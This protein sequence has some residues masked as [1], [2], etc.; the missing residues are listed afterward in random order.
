[1]EP[2]LPPEVESGLAQSLELIAGALLRLAVAQERAAIA[3]DRAARALERQA[4][5]VP[6]LLDD[7]ARWLFSFHGH[8]LPAF[9][10]KEPEQVKDP[11]TRTAMLARTWAERLHDWS[12]PKARREAKWAAEKAQREAAA[13][14]EAGASFANN[15]HQ[16]AQVDDT[17]F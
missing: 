14:A 7:E 11:R 15:G 16:P 1:M 8:T 3:Q 12:L 2:A 17:P 9:V 13:L 10:P 5:T 4:L 6:E